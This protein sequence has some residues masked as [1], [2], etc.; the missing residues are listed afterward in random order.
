MRFHIAATKQYII[1]AIETRGAVAVLEDWTGSD[2]EAIAAV[3][4]DPRE[5]FA[6]GCDHYGPD[7]HCLGHEGPRKVAE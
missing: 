1:Q 5:Y 7:G 4:D 6:C 3:Q 2:A